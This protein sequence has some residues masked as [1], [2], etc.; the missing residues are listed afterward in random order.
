VSI[1]L[2]LRRNELTSR[3]MAEQIAAEEEKKRKRAEKF[4]TGKPAAENGTA[5]PVS[6]RLS[7]GCRDVNVN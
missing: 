5:E 3:E 2:S 4:G 7:S 1:L 6:W